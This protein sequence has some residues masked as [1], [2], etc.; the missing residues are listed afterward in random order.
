M[1]TS[2]RAGEVTRQ[3]AAEPGAPVAQE[4]A[5]AAV[6]AD[7][8]EL[9]R[10]IERTREELG[11]TVEQLVAKADVKSRAQARASEFAG[12]L[13]ARV[14]QAQQQASHRADSMRG[15]LAGTAATAQQRVTAAAGPV[16]EATP[17]PLRQ[18]VSKGASTARQRRVPLAAGAAGLLLACYLVVRR[19]RSH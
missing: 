7:P 12:L 3:Q 11:D 8:Q 15:Q 16:W 1:S 13:K 5:G 6:P 18:A 14:G 9:K 19:R 10:E 4:G 2:K 17:E